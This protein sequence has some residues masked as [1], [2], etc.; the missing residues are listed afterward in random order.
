MEGRGWK[1]GDHDFWLLYTVLNFEKC[2][3]YS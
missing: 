1:E 3:S 2:V